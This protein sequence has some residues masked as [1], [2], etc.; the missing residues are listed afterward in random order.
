[1]T[2]CS[3]EDSLFPTKAAERLKEQDRKNRAGAKRE[4]KR[5]EKKLS[6]F[7]AVGVE[8]KINS[9]KLREQKKL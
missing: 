9:V 3:G 8:E 1:M 2:P 7:V 5:E 4:K 6:V